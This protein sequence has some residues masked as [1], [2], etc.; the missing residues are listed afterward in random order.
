MLASSQPL[1]ITVLPASTPT[2]AVVVP[3]ITSPAPGAELT[4][5]NL[6]DLAGTGRPGDT[7]HIFD[8]NTDLDAATVGPDG[9]WR[10]PFPALGSGNHVMTAR[11]VDANGNDLAISQ[12]LNITIV[13]AAS[14]T[15]TGGTPGTTPGATP[16]SGGTPA[17]TPG[18]SSTPGT[19]PSATPGSGGTPAATPGI[20]PTLTPTPVG[21]PSGGR[22]KSPAL[23]SPLV[24][25]C[26]LYT[27]PSPRD[28]TRSRMPSSA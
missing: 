13:D 8:G 11:A 21:T 18:S 4:A 22:V 2:P 25:P 26:L 1:N 19:T 17:A 24:S 3:T 14:P 5:G 12:P 15:P 9:A 27:S 6:G 10:F 7:L 16:G 20:T 28:R 23:S